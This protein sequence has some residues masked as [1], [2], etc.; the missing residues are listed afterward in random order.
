MSSKPAPEQTCPFTLDKIDFSEHSQDYLIYVPQEED[1][2]TIYFIK[3]DHLES[4]GRCPRCPVT[5][6]GSPYK[7]VQLREFEAAERAALHF[8]SYRN[9]DT[10]VSIKQKIDAKEPCNFNN[11]A[12]QST[13]THLPFYRSLN[14]HSHHSGIFYSLAFGRSFNNLEMNDH[15]VSYNLTRCGNEFANSN[16]LF[17]KVLAVHEV[18][19]GNHYD[20]DATGNGSKGLVDFLIFPLIARRLI[21]DRYRP[22][23]ANCIKTLIAYTIAIP[24]EIARFSISTA[25]TLLTL[26]FIVLAHLASGCRPSHDNDHLEEE[27]G[28]TLFIN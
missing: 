14:P 24:L 28:L 15:L 22:E 20:L 5:R 6:S 3:D 4:M 10:E 7:F 27:S 25:I 23:A 11:N 18:L 1:K 16:S 21:A 9:T 19:C 8:D 26:P 13:A 2:Y 12:M 17:N